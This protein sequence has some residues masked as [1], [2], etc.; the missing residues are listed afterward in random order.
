M[1]IFYSTSYDIKLLNWSFKQVL[2]IK[3]S[4]D[5]LLKEWCL[6]EKKQSCTVYCV[7]AHGFTEYIDISPNDEGRKMFTNKVN[8][9]RKSI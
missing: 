4:A 2:T 3:S 1:G 9:G 8:D 6:Y 5:C 7:T